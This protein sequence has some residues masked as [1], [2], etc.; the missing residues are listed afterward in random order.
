MA[1]L[2]LCSERPGIT[3]GTNVC[4]VCAQVIADLTGIKLLDGYP[5]MPLRTTSSQAYAK[6]FL[7][8]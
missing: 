6:D 3:A 2:E 8:R 5:V 7:S 1:G 4:T